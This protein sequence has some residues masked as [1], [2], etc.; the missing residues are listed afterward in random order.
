MALVE[1]GSGPVGF[2]RSTDSGV[3]W[4]YLPLPSGLASTFGAELTCS[5]PDH[6]LVMSDPTFTVPANS[7]VSTTDGGQSWQQMQLPG[8]AQLFNVSCASS[9]VCVAGSA[10]ATDDGGTR[11]PTLSVSRDGGA[12][13][14]TEAMPVPR[15]LKG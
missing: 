6:C 8:N 2:L 13:W 3:S 9:D 14:T 4:G 5:G 1:A 7:G 10:T 15:L 11:A 12:T